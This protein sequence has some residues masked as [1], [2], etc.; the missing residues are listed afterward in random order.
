MWGV[1]TPYVAQGGA[2]KVR[3]VLNELSADS[4]SHFSNENIEHQ[5][6]GATCGRFHM[7]RL[8]F[9]FKDVISRVGFE[10]GSVESEG[11]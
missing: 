10:F 5:A 6:I 2:L 8:L 1:G 3:A 9:S 4:T 7:L 11:R